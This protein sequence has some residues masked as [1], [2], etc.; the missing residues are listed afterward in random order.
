MAD[1]G[2]LRVAIVRDEE[3]G[4]CR[5]TVCDSGSGIPQPILDRLFQPFVTGKER[6]TGL[7]LAI[8]RRIVEE[9]GGTLSA[10]NRPGDGAIFT[11]ELPSV[12]H[13]DE[14]PCAVGALA[15]TPAASVRT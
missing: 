14:Q 8:S 3:S 7:G 2:A 10:A 11:V 1:G 15:D 9:H 13:R 4:R 6:G 12:Q 5:A